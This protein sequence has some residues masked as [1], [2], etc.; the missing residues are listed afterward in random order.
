MLITGP[1]DLGVLTEEKPATAEE[2]AAL[3]AR[4]EG[5][6]EQIVARA[7]AHG[8][9]VIGCTL[10]PWM[11]FSYYHP[12]AQNEADRRAVN[13]WLRTPGRFDALLDFDKVLGDPAN[14]AALAPLYDSGDRLHPGPKGYQAMA[15]AVPLTLF[16]PAKPRKPAKHK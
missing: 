8:I 6:Y 12:D 7:H 9:K 11:G 13:A 4:V 1:W 5:A 2:H 10:M 15:D 16:S 14:P 3:I